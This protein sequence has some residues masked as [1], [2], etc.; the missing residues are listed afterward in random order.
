MDHAQ[1]PPCPTEEI[2]VSDWRPSVRSLFN[3][4]E[5]G[6][7]KMNADLEEFLSE[8]ALTD[9]DDFVSSLT[10]DPIAEVWEAYGCYE[11]FKCSPFAGE[12][13]YYTIFHHN[14]DLAVSFQLPFDAMGA[15]AGLGRVILETRTEQIE[16]RIL[17]RA[18]SEAIHGELVARIIKVIPTLTPFSDNEREEYCLPN[19]RFLAP[20]ADGTVIF[21]TPPQLR[22][23]PWKG[24]ED[25]LAT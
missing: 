12:L 9:L 5:H 23:V 22:G 4:L 6:D 16:G 17:D 11:G 14:R 13:G 1:A 8:A 21:L 3:N 24:M 15:L 19:H 2:S 10:Y 7:P 25:G 20:Q 18:T